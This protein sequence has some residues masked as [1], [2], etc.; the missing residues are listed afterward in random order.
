MGLIADMESLK[1]PINV[2]AHVTGV[3]AKGEVGRV[4]PQRGFIFWGKMQR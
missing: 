2:T 4:A 3:S 1:Q